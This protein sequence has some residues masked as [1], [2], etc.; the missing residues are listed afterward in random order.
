MSTPTYE[1]TK[2]S[3]WYKKARHARSFFVCRVLS[4]L[5]FLALIFSVD[6]HQPQHFNFEQH[7]GDPH[8]NL[9]VNAHAHSTG[10]HRSYVMHTHR[11]TDI[12]NTGDNHSGIAT[13]ETSYVHGRT[14][15]GQ[16]AYH[17]H[18][19][20]VSISRHHNNSA[21]HE[22]SPSIAWTDPDPPQD[23]STPNPSIGG[24]DDNSDNQDSRN[25]NRNP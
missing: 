2:S 19:Y 17:S 21:W 25:G 3:N 14:Q 18:P 5:S 15:N 12:W 22:H 7:Y 10:N 4:I 23:T 9:R 11:P 20:V 13:V 1:I 16:T 8:T 6:A 24:N